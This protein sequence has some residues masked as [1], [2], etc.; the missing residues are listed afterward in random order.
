MVATGPMN[1]YV[2]QSKP[3]QEE[4]ADENLR[5]WHVETLLPKLLRPVRSARAQRTIEPLFP[6][7]LFARFDADGMASKVRYTRGV[8]RVLGTES[9]P[10]AVDD[11]IIDEIKRR[12]D[13]GGLVRP[14]ST[15][16]AGDRVRIV[17]GPLKDFV[18]VF[19]YSATA[20]QRVT[21]LLATLHSPVRVA[22]DAHLVE[23]VS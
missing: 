20:A 13:P 15:L 23:R 5:A 9:G 7:Y 16:R 6:G 12:M 2:I 18:G 8:A 4:R 14:T 3:K 1:W 22:L 21:L 11:R 10:S 19:E 17:S